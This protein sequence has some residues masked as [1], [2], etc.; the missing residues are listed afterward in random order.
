MSEFIVSIIIKAAKNSVEEGI[1]KYQAYFINTDLYLRYKEDLDNM[2]TDNSYG[3][4][5]VE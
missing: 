1:V 4:V 3:S 2:L 5:I